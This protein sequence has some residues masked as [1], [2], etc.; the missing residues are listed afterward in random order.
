MPMCVLPPAMMMMHAAAQPDAVGSS[1][2][3]FPWLAQVDDDALPW[4]LL[5]KDSDPLDLSFDFISSVLSRSITPPMESLPPSPLSSSPSSSY[6]SA[7]DSRADSPTF[8]SMIMEDLLDSAEELSSVASTPLSRSSPNSPFSES[9]SP[10]HASPT[11]RLGRRKSTD[12]ASAGKRQPTSP[13]VKKTAAKSDLVKQSKRT[14]A[15]ALASKRDSHNISER[16]RRQELKLS[17]TALQG[18][19]PNLITA[20]RAHTGTVLKET[21]AYIAALEQEEKNLLAAKQALRHEHQ[22]FAIVA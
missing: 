15:M 2:D 9:L 3:Y 1:S 13:K 5:V 12:S 10:S 19:V 6:G 4:D 7:D 16:N 17:F 20:N 14:K 8:L 21:I 11:Q 22:R 18:L